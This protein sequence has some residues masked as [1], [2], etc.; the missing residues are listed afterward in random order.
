MQYPNRIIKKGEGNKD[1]VKAIQTMLNF[2][3]CGPLRVDGIFG[4]QTERAVK[5]FQ[6]RHVDF[7]GKALLADGIVGPITWQTLFEVEITA[8]KATK[9]LLLKAVE[10]AK[11]QIGV[12]EQPLNTNRG[13]EVDAYLRSVGL[14]PE[15]NNY[16][17]CAAF[18]YW[19]FQEAAAHLQT[20]NPLVKTAGVL[21]HWQ[22]TTG[23]KVSLEEAKNNPSLIQVGA[24]FIIDHGRGLGHTGI[25]EQ[26]SGG[27]LTTI[28]GNTNNSRSRNGYGVFRL[29]TRKVNNIN[30]GFIIY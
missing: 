5:L 15:G 17:W 27:N 9:E 28:E 2:K 30:K 11:T 26:I 3:K 29:N 21:K 6:T 8:P 13:P 7:T 20:S 1:I 24:I 14:N 22:K 12:V 23:V 16:S 18:V 10:I 25:V 19:C 4:P